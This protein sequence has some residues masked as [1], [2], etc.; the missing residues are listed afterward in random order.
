MH[1]ET[2]RPGRRVYWNE[3]VHA[4]TFPELSGDITV[5]VVIVGG[6]IVGVTTARLLKDAGL[7]V[8]VVEARRV[9]R[10]ATG[11][12]TA[13]VTSQHGIVYQTLVQK[14]GEDR[15]RLY[16]QA[17]EAGVAKIRDLAAQWSI[18]CDLEARPHITYTRDQSYV[19]KI[20]EE[21]EIAHKLGLPAS[22]VHDTDLPFEV[23]AALRFENQGQ[24][25]PV[26]YLAGLAASIPGDGSHLFENS[27]VVDWD[28]ARVATD[29]GT[30]S[31]QVVVMATH[32]PLGQIGGYYAQAYPHAHPVVAA[33]I[34]RVP[35]ANYIS[36][37]QPK[38]SIRTHRSESGEVYGI[39]TGPSFKPGHVDEERKSFEGLE[40]W[41]AEH[42]GAGPAE[43]R[44]VNEDYT[45]MDG[46]PFVGWAKG[47][48][49]LVATGFDA[50]GISNGTAAGMI[51]ADLAQDRDHPWLEIF[52]A[53]RVKPLAGGTEFA[54]ENAAVA[55]HLIGGYLSHKPESFGELA[56]GEAA[57]MKIDGENVAAF[58]DEQGAVHAVS[59]VCSHMGCLVGWNETDRTW[60]CPC[61]GSRFELSGEVLHGP[62]TRPL[63]SKITG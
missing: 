3:T 6:G 43:Y 38:R 20:E 4:D 8:A 25:H 26:K 45:P 51:L 34:E 18:E 63:G 59:A 10:Q 28:P 54:K 42:F 21:A 7:N 32:L 12:S 44:W 62:A 35:A 47:Q 1:D 17:Q 5:D 27:R 29:H 14:F 19:S 15:A 53:K 57:V 58:K 30:V 40:S 24:F 46:A 52:D 23:L 55:K 13:K 60:D 31:A 33:R 61:H 11:K 49:Y 39:A 48:D 36:A 22:L 16:A 41:L 37:E 2:P 56:P 9:G 50:W